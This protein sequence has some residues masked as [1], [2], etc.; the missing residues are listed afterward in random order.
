MHISH[1]RREIAFPE[2]ERSMW[3]EFA[4]L[5]DVTF[6]TRQPR[7]SS[8]TVH[9]LLLICLIDGLVPVV[10]S[11]RQQCDIRRLKVR[12]LPRYILIW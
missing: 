6:L 9:L 11:L 7:H 1:K 2:P 5:V 4:A 3:F 12:Q 10:I 8:P